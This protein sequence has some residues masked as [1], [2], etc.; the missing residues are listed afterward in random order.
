MH[1]EHHC[2]SLSNSSKPESQSQP[3]RETTFKVRAFPI[4]KNQNT[5]MEIWDAGARMWSYYNLSFSLVPVTL[6][7]LLKIHS[8]SIPKFREEL[9]YIDDKALKF[10]QMDEQ[11]HSS[12]VL[13]EFYPEASGAVSDPYADVQRCNIHSASDIVFKEADRLLFPYRN[14]EFGYSNSGSLPKEDIHRP[15][16]TV[17]GCGE[18]KLHCG[19]NL[20]DM[21]I[22]AQQTLDE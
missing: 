16:P 15:V 13:P 2:E 21:L 14:F 10:L 8:L 5:A 11:Q 17:N 20:S 22:Q 7:S 12:T 4:Q 1:P 9:T 18:F 6:L 3:A 19:E